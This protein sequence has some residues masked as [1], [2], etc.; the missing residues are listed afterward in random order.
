VDVNGNIATQYSYD[1]F[2]NTTTS[3]AASSNPSQYTGRENEGN[4]LYSYRA[5]YYSSQ[6]GRFIN[7]D[8]IGFGGGAN[9][10]AYVFDSPTNLVDPSGNCPACLEPPAEIAVETAGAGAATTTVVATTAGEGSAPVMTLIAEG[11]AG[12]SEAGPIGV[13]AGIGIAALTGI[14]K[15]EVQATAAV[16]DE[17]DAYAAE[18]QSIALYNKEMMRHPPLAG[19]ACK[20]RP[21]QGDDDCNSQFEA[22]LHSGLADL[23]GHVYGSGRC[24]ECRQACVR[25]G[26]NWPSSSLRTRGSVRCDYW[27]FTSTLE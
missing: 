6:L 12:G 22:C 10:Y 7:E 5:R 4:G 24:E 2:G 25:N 18:M 14:L 23:D 17:N 3:G 13:V 20:T 27:N 19:R 26:G 11:S 9:L 15:A 21:E 1:P 16:M 8:P